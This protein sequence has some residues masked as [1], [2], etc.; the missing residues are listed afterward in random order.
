[1]ARS[2]RERPRSSIGS[3]SKR[4]T[5]KQARRAVVIDFEGWRGGVE[6]PREP[7]LLGVVIG[8]VLLR[9][10]FCEALRPFINSAAARHRGPGRRFERAVRPPEQVVSD[11]VDRAER[12]DRL[13]VSYSLV[14][15]R[16]IESIDRA[17]AARAGTR[18]VNGKVAVD[19][20]WRISH[21]RDDPPPRDLK[22]LLRTKA[23]RYVLP[24]PSVEPGRVLTQC[25]NAAKKYRRMRRVP[26]PLRARWDQLLEY[27]ALD[28]RGLQRVVVMATNGLAMRTPVRKG[29]IR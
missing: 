3:R 23:P 8:R 28:C 19:R 27:N 5:P 7:R 18:F 26:R 9:A 15:L 21:R 4:L 29:A 12:E 2:E 1:M 22:T 13:I 14:E 16:L 11:L 20:W 24:G 25:A 17:L 10:A 6:D